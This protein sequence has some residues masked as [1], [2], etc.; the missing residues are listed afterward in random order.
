MKIYDGENLILGRLA[1]YVAKEALQGEEVKV[2]NCAKIVISGKKTNTFAREKQRRERGGNPLTSPR[3][4]RLPYLFVRRTIRGM[5]PRKQARGREA[6][7]RILCYSDVPAEFTQEKKITVPEASA[8][9][10]PNLKY[11]TIGELC[12][13]LGGKEI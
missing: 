4:S 1:A 12:R 8:K 3:I 6:Y 5:L 13:Q 2:V 7:H 11:T 9:K 10:L